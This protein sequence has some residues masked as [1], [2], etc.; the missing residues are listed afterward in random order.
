MLGGLIVDF[1]LLVIGWTEF[2]W[3]HY[4]NSIPPEF[5]YRLEVF[6]YKRNQKD[7]L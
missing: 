7:L 3:T 1:K 5:G 2:C 4:R 6:Q